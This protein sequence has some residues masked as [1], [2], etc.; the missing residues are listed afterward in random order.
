MPK[1]KLTKAQVKR[2]LTT[3]INSVYDL[4]LDKLGYPDSFVPMSKPKALETLENL[5]KARLRVK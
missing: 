2:K 3:A 5:S 4:V 1:K